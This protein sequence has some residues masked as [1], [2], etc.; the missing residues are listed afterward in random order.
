MPGVAHTGARDGPAANEVTVGDVGV[1][2]CAF[3]A[4]GVGEVEDLARAESRRVKDPERRKQRICVVGGV[5]HTGGGLFRGGR[6]TGCAR[7]DGPRIRRAPVPSRDLVGQKRG[8][9]FLLGLG[10]FALGAQGGPRRDIVGPGQKNGLL[11]A[12]LVIA[13]SLGIFPHAGG[14]HRNFLVHRLVHIERCAVFAP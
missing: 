11:F 12:P 1:A 7:G 8:K 10:V 5:G 6:N 13:V 3:G 9:G 4:E 14:A 2:L